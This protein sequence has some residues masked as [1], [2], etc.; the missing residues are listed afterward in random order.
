MGRKIKVETYLQDI[1]N[2]IQKYEE[3]K[4]WNSNIYKS[5]DKIDA[6]TFLAETIFGSGC[7]YISD[8]IDKKFMPASTITKIKERRSAILNLIKNQTI[9]KKRDQKSWDKLINSIAEEVLKAPINH[10]NELVWGWQIQ[11]NMTLND[12]LNKPFEAI[13]EL[14]ST[15]GRALFLNHWQRIWRHPNFKFQNWLEDSLGFIVTENNAD[16]GNKIN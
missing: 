6:V 16:K 2:N 13:K 10:Y 9:F 7:C 8:I 12:I 11:N 14:T 15:R 4:F 1:I 3:K 5:S